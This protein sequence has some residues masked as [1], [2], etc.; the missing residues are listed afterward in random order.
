M[1]ASTDLSTLVSAYH[2]SS[3]PQKL[4]NLIKRSSTL[5][6]HPGTHFHQRCCVRTTRTHLS[7]PFDLRH[8]LH[9]VPTQ[10]M[11]QTQDNSFSLTVHQIRIACEES[12]LASLPRPHYTQLCR[13]SLESHSTFMTVTHTLA[14]YTH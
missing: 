10:A 9:I 12:A 11:S 1:K 14:A 3:A 4:N 13:I 5:S 7:V 2:A 8:L 6:L